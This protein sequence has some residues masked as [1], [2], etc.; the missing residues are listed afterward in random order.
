MKDPVIIVGTGALAHHALEILQK[1]DIIIYGLL[2]EKQEA[3]PTEINHIPILGNIEENASYLENIDKHC[4]VFV[5]ME[6][7]TSRQQYIKKASNQHQ[8]KFINL[9][10]PLANLAFNTL[11]GIGNLIDA[12]ANIS[13]NTQLGNHCLIHKQVI[14]EYG[15]TIQN[16]VQIG[17]G[18]I[19][20]EQVTIE[21]DVFIG[22]GVTII[23]GTHIRKGARIG[24]GSV[25]LESVKE[26]EVVLGNPAKPF[27]IN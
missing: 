3:R 13:A 11:L 19:I 6:Q 16:F 20:G 4:A 22:P 10:H 24:A 23:A 8:I 17:S 21:E 9:V 14:I 5:A 1:N 15:A 25:V 18:S 12:G 2:A 27:K 7:A 26:K